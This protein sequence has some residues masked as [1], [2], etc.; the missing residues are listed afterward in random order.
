ME[1]TKTQKILLGIASGWPLVYIFIFI[2][3]IFGMI[4]LTAG[5]PGS[6]NEFN[7]LLGGGF[8]VL[9]IV[10]MLTIFLTLALT[11]FYIV[12]AVKNTKLDSNMRIIWIVLFFF[13]GMIAQPIYW[14]LQVWKEPETAATQLNPPP[15]SSWAD[16]EDMRQGAYVPPSEPP[17]WR[18]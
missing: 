17:D 9:M 4:A 15:A 11:V 2:A 13:G 10:H 8:V 3:F 16:Q 12:H 5:G 18:S 14:Y 7:P 6:G 1:L